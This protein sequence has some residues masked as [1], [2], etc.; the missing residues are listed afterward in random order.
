MYVVK[1][2]YAYKIY[3]I[4]AKAIAGFVES[5]RKNVKYGD[6][7]LTLCDELEVFAER[8]RKR[9][10]ELKSESTSTTHPSPTHHPS[11]IGKRDKAETRKG[12]EEYLALF[13]KS[14]VVR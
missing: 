3:E 5:F 13:E 12:A 10:E 11:D 6:D 4:V 14:K 1:V 2:E 8:L 9:A 7:L